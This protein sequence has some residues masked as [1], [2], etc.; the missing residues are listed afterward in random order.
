[1]YLLSVE[2]S[3]NVTINVQL[4]KCYFF[5]KAH[6]INRFAIESLLCNDLI[7]DLS[8]GCQATLSQ[9]F[10]KVCLGHS[11]IVLLIPTYFLYCEVNVMAKRGLQRRFHL[12]IEMSMFPT[13]MFSGC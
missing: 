12:Y 10:N 6:I 1:M 3:L 7:F 9:S 5:R 8:C 4:P 13:C 11:S 2:D